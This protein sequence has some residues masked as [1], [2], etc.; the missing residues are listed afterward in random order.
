MEQNF[1]LP[2]GGAGNDEWMDGGKDC[3][4][5]AG[6][7]RGRGNRVSDRID[8]RRSFNLRIYKTQV[9]Q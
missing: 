3:W 1:S 7:L 5:T 9:S 2:Q 8:E 4:M 6:Q